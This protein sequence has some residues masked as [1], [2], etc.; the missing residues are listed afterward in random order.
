MVESVTVRSYVLF[1]SFLSKEPRLDKT[2]SK[3]EKKCYQKF[4]WGTQRRAHRFCIRVS[5]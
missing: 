1:P 3:N 2:E 4:E 5:K